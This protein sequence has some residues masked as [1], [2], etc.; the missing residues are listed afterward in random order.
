MRLEMNA[1][2]DPVLRSAGPAMWFERP[3]GSQ[4]PCGMP[5]LTNLF[6]TPRRV[7]LGVG[8]SEVGELRDVDRSK[9]DR[10]G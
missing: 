9:A 4:D 7:A 2:S 3:V 8:A 6:G 1:L 10:I 5:A